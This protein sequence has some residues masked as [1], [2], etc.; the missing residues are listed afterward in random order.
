[1]SE[2]NTYHLPDLI[3]LEQ[4]NGNFTSFLEAVY[5]L[6]KNDFINTKPIF[7]GIRLGL[8]RH[9]LSE[10]KEATF[11][12]I[13]SEGENESTRIPDLRRMERIKWPA[14]LI[15]N[16]THPY[17]MVWENKRGNKSNILVFHEK[18]QYLVVLRK[19]KDY[20]LLWTAYLIED[21]VRKNKLI[22]EYNAYINA[23]SAQQ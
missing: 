12:H 5:L 21:N 1:M 4:Y 19:V 16:S 20:L 8:K 7:R 11:W 3:L 10:G 13:T 15:N 14:N 6:F 23:E 18:E 9:P 17:L 2:N 22:K